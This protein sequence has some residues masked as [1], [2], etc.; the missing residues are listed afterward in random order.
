MTM[1][2]MVG[3]I[4][5]AAPVVIAVLGAL[6]HTIYWLYECRKYGGDW[7]YY[8]ETLSGIVAIVAFGIGCLLVVIGG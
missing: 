2:A 3:I 6:F 7:R 1:K 8:A 4:L 5:M